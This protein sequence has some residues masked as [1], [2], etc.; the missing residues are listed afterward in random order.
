MVVGG[1]LTWSG[2]AGMGLFKTVARVRR[3]VAVNRRG[4]LLSGHGDGLGLKEG[5]R[6]ARVLLDASVPFRCEIVLYKLLDTS[7]GAFGSTVD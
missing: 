3:V 1:G 4:C 5:E 6:V 2:V 7:L